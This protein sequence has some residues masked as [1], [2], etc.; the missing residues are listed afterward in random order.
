MWDCGLVFPWK[1]GGQE[2]RHDRSTNDAYLIWAGRRHI[3]CFFSVDV[4]FGINLYMFVG[5]GR[6]Q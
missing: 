5:E 2:S 1:I 4:N 3:E 6:F